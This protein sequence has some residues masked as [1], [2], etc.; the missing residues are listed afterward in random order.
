MDHS[1][2]NAFLENNTEWTLKI[3]LQIE[4]GLQIYFIWSS[5]CLKIKLN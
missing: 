1:M 4:F 3:N 2:G 5:Q